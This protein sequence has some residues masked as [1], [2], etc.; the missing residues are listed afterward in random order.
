MTAAILTLLVTL[1]GVVVASGGASA[2]TAPQASPRVYCARVGTD[3]TL[4]R[5]PRSLVPAIHRLFGIEGSY[6]RATT[7]YR[8]AHGIVL[9][10]TVGANLSC[11]KADAGTA[12]PAA[13]QWCETHE[14]SDF[15]PMVV[16]GHDTIYSWRCV[17]RRAEPGSKTGT[18]DDRGFLR[19]NWKT[20][21]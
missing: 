9:L 4:R 18:V 10:C 6:A 19:Q 1:L 15:V 8:C 11:G 14:N 5:P 7:Y 20:L 12:M 2:A 16:T 21:E 13:D 3:D 17:G